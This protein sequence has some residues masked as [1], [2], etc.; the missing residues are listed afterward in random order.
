MIGHQTFEI[1]QTLT[2]KCSL[3]TFHPENSKCSPST[4]TNILEVTPLLRKAYAFGHRSGSISLKKS[5]MS[6]LSA[7]SCVER[8]AR[9]FF[10]APAKLQMCDDQSCHVRHPFR[11]CFG[12][13][14]SCSHTSEGSFC[15]EINIYQ[16]RM[17]IE[18][19]DY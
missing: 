15:L 9:R 3:K 1:L 18:T 4:N 10:P 19:R 6:D 13:S 2:R 16:A 17:F 7:I 12:V 8:L 5:S 14:C 11:A